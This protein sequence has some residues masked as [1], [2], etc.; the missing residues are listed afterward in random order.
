VT[1]VIALGAISGT[2]FI[3]FV[4]DRYGRR[5]AIFFGTMVTVVGAILQGFSKKQYEQPTVV[6]PTLII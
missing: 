5:F 1:A 4:G 6:Y 3:S 2:P